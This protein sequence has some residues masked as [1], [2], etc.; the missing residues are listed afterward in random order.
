MQTQSGQ[1]KINYELTMLKLS[2]NN[3]NYRLTSEMKRRDLNRDNKILIWG[4]WKMEN[5]ARIELKRNEVKWSWND[6][7]GQLDATIMIYW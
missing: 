6:F 5:L 2:P 1:I 4:K 7:L 3:K